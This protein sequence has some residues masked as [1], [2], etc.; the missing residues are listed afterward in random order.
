MAPWPQSPRYCPPTLVGLRAIDSLIPTPTALNGVDDIN[1]RW[2]SA[3]ISCLA[4]NLSDGDHLQGFP[5]LHPFAI[6]H[7]RTGK[8]KHGKGS[9]TQQL[10]GWRERTEYIEAIRR[11]LHDQ[12]TLYDRLTGGTTI[13]LQHPGATEPGII[14]LPENLKSDVYLNPRMLAAHPELHQTAAEII[15]L[16][17]ER[18]AS[19]NVEDF[20]SARR[21]LNWK[22]ALSEMVA[23]NNQQAVVN[24]Y[25]QPLIPEP[26]DPSSAHFVIK[27]RPSGVLQELFRTSGGRVASF[28]P[29]QSTPC[30]WRSQQVPVNISTAISISPTASNPT[31]S[32]LA[33]A[34]SSCSVH[35]DVPPTPPFV[36]LPQTPLRSQV[37]EKAHFTKLNISASSSGPLP[38]SNRVTP[39]PPAPEQYIRTPSSSAAATPS[40]TP[41]RFQPIRSFGE[42]TAAALRS[43]RL[44]DKIHRVCHKLVEEVAKE[45]WVE[46]MV[47]ENV[48]LSN[49][50]RLLGRSRAPRAKKSPA[51]RAA[52][53]LRRRDNRVLEDADVNDVLNYIDNKATELATKHR[54]S[55]RRFL[56]KFFVGSSLRRRRRTKT[57]AWSAYMYF[58]AQTANAGKLAGTKESIRELVKNTSDY[59]TLAPEER[60]SL[61]DELDRIKN[62]NR[63][64]PPA[65]NAKTRAAEASSSFASVREELGGLTERLGTE[66]FVVLVRG[67]VDYQMEPKVFFTSE[68]AHQFLRIYLRKDPMEMAL[69]FESA[70]LAEGKQGGGPTNY[71]SKVNAAKAA[72]RTGLTLD[73]IQI[74]KDSSAV[75]EYKTYEEDIVKKYQVKLVGWAHNEWA[76]PSDIKGGLAVLEQLAAAVSSGTCK[77]VRI[78]HEEVE[79]RRRRIANGEIVT[80][81]REATNHS[82]TAATSS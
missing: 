44:P 8:S 70:I 3:L 55:R 46:E 66:A 18:W 48:T 4:H 53:D 38:Q 12:C 23:P 63:S 33:T 16:F 30:V 68:K 77:F 57:S 69:K 25:A 20:R 65:I 1:E 81:D 21:A 54:R 59:H 72:I 82:P 42:N 34:S 35:L 29:S 75:M 19:A 11:G 50:R 37:D 74:T 6:D 27:G 62:G 71:K 45:R 80:P 61:I 9:Q 2:R 58:R 47:A 31:S 14:N 43:L 41:S 49:V 76:N 67:S 26:I 28:L 36:A 39:I 60:Q 52:I 7:Y 73:L 78:R 79:E 32:P 51:D 56:E 10:A 64:K 17:L 22:P 5:S 13:L 40:A 15:Q 24:Y